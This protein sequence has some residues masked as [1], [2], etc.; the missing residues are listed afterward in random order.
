MSGAVL[1]VRGEP[2]A[3][4]S[5]LYT[6]C[7]AADHTDEED[8]EAPVSKPEANDTKAVTGQRNTDR[9]RLI[10][11]RLAGSTGQVNLYSPLCSPN[12]TGNNFKD[13]KRV[14]KGNIFEV[15]SNKIENVKNSNKRIK[16]FSHAVY[17]NKAH[18]P[19]LMTP[20]E[21]RKFRKKDIEH[22]FG[23]KSKYE[24][25]DSTTDGGSEKDGCKWTFVFDPAGRFAYWWSAVISI[26]F[27]YNFWV[28]VYR[29]AFEEINSSNLSF[30]FSLDYIAD[31]LYVLDIVFHFRTGYLE[32]G[33]LQTDGVKLR[34]HYMNSTMFYID[35][36]CLLPLD[37]LYLSIGFKSML[38]CFRLVKIYR[39]W[40]FLDRTERH[41]NYPN[42][43][44]TVT[45]LHYLMAIYHWNACVM[46]TVISHLDN[47]NWNYPKD[48]TDVF[49]MYLHS[50]Y[51]STLTLTTIGDLPQPTVKGEYVF[52]IVQ[53]IFGLLLFSAVLGHVANIVA[54]ISFAR[55]DFQGK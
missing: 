43:I 30:W 49:T 6:A 53:F 44:R 3:G 18:N 12:K 36:L 40:A 39:F 33:V 52:V 46:Y 51:F 34:L 13:I 54:S 29:F 45:L 19:E 24:R 9:T 26:S 1:R 42:V 7:N 20:K 17:V 47:G 23:K 2:G 48:K 41:T 15:V 10:G 55:K 27:I 31:F 11:E 32:D 37:F 50:L 38:R 5:V 16:D 14:S 21:I 35:C 28:I 4:G 25:I 8:I 22:K